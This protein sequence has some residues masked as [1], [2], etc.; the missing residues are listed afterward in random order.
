MIGYV[1]QEPTLFNDTIFNNILYGKPF[2]SEDQVIEAAKKSYAY[3]F[4]MEKE[5]GFK[6]QLGEDG[7]KLSLGEKQRISIARALLKD[8]P[9]M[10]LDEATSALDYN[11]EL[12]VRKAIK[13]LTK[14]RTTIIIA[15]RLSTVRTADKILVINQGRIVEQGKHEELL[16]LDGYYKEMYNLEFV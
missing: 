16:E 1:N 6:Y 7:G 13:E 14:N 10:I 3:D 4:I 12:I 8:S 11:S 15:H 5:L 2:S 9:I